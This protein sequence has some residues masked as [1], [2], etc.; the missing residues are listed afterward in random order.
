[1]LQKKHFVLYGL[2]QCDILKISDNEIQWLTGEEDFTKGVHWILE[3][4]HIPLI[5]VSMGKEGSRAYYKDLIVEAKPFI[6]KNTIETTGAGDTFC[7]CVLHYV[8]EHGL[9]DLTENGLKE[10]LTFANAAAS[11]ITTRKGALRVMPEREEVEKLLS[12]FN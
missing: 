9:T 4:Y 6:Q 5:L 1:M 7:A 10:M 2:G 3:G 12:C 8:L 11:I